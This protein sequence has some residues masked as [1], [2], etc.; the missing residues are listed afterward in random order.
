VQEPLDNLRR[1]GF[2]L[3]GF[4]RTESGLGENLRAIARTCET[5]GI[6]VAVSD[7]DVEVGMRKTDCSVEHL[8]A[9]RPL[10]RQRIVLANPDMLDEAIHHDGVAATGD[11]YKIGY[12]AWELEKPPVSWV[13]ASRLLNELWLPSEFVRRAFAGAI[14]IPAYTVPTPIRTPRPSRAY[15]RSEFN[16]R[17]DEIVFLFSFAYSSL[18][19]RKNPWAVVRAFRAAFPAGIADVRLVVKT[20]QSDLHQA[21]AQSLRELA[22]DDPRILFIDGFMSRDQMMGLQNA[23]DCLVS[24]HRSEGFGLGM[25]E[26]MALGKTVIA[27]AYSANLDFMNERNSL[28]VDYSLIP[29]KPGEY[30]YAEGQV[31]A[32]ADIESAARHMRNAYADAGL[33]ARLGAAAAAFMSERY[34]EQAIG[35]LLQSQLRRIAGT[36]K[37]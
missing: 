5:A 22:A 8:I 36:W 18:A 15:A 10:F 1:D 12:W 26:C 13:R 34:S 2:D 28:L 37:P 9:A 11:V 20:V 21:D 4:A 17:D 27:T 6:P 25:A 3:V 19:T 23:C 31:W 7:V 30:P 32:D 16:L 35:S 29:L 14:A 33:R 24:L